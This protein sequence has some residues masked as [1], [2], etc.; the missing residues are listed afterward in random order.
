MPLL[1][2]QTYADLPCYIG[3]TFHS[4]GRC[5]NKRRAKLWENARGFGSYT[6]VPQGYQSAYRATIPTLKDSGFAA[7]FLGASSD[8]TASLTATGN[9]SITLVGAAAI[10]A[11]ANAAWNAEAVLTGEATI[12]PGLAALGNASAKLDTGAQPSAFDIAQETM[13][14]IVESGVSLKEVLRLLL[15][16]AAGD[17]TNLDTNPAFKS[18]D[19]TKTR[20]A[21]T[22]SGGTRNITTLDPS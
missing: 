22:R 7:A 9:L 18:V 21:G 12:T 2:N 6:S 14:Q 15:A 13:G 8:Q 3:G 16:V 11:N 4:T 5:I 20:V 10:A 1:W 17:A 19:G